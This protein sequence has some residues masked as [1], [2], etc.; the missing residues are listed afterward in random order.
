MNI[1]VGTKSPT[2]IMSEDLAK[3]GLTYQ[4]MMARLID[5]SV[6]TTID[7]HNNTKG[8]VIPYFD[9]AGRLTQFYRVKVLGDPKIKYLQIKGAPNHV[10]FPKNWNQS[11]NAV[12][13]KFCILTEG[14]KKAALACKMG[15]PAVAF[16]GVD[17]W[18][19]KTLL[20]PK[21]TEQSTGPNN[22]L[23]VKLPS[24]EFD[25]LEEGVLALG[26]QELIDYGLRSNTTWLIIYDSDSSQGTIPQVQRA[27]ARLG[28]ELRFKGFSVGQIRQMIIPSEFAG[29]DGRASL[30]DVLLSEDGHKVF[31]KLMEENF[32]QR[33][34]F[35]V[36]PNVREHI[37]KQLQKP[38]LDRKSAMNIS[39]ALLTDLDIKGTRMYSPDDLQMYYFSQTTHHLM[40]VD[41]N[42]QN[43]ASV[44][45]TEFGQL[46]YRNY[47][48]STTAD[49]RLMQWFGA[50]FSGE[51][52]VE[53]V[54]PFRIVGKPKP[55]EDIVRLQINNGSYIKISADGY[56]VMP[57]GS[58]GTLFES[59]NIQIQ[60]I[61]G[62]KLTAEIQ[63]RHGEVRETGI[64]KCWWLE[65]MNEVRL[66]HPGKQAELM[67]LLFYM[68]PF[69]MRWRGTQLPAEIVVGEA[70]S[71]K[72]TLCEI[73][74]NILCGDPKLRN[75][76]KD[77]KDWYA[78]LANCGGITVF[79]NMHMTDKSLRQSMSDEL[80]RLI[81]ELDPRISMRKYYTEADE[82]S[83]RINSV[84]GFTAIQMPFTNPD[85]LQRAIV[86]EL[87]KQ[88]DLGQI[89]EGGGF[90]TTFD[91]GWKD[92][93]LNRYGGRTAWLAHHCF[94]LHQFF[95]AVKQQWK[96][97]YQ[98]K[99][100]LV[101]L[102]QG[103]MIMAKV[104]G[105]DPSWIPSYLAQTTD[106]QISSNDWTMEGLSE[107]AAMMRQKTAARDT[108]YKYNPKVRPP[109]PL[110]FTSQKIADWAAS[111]EEHEKN[112][113]ISNTRSLGRYMQ[114]NKY[115]IAHIC[116]IVEDGKE[117]NRIRYRITEGK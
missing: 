64:P 77:Q 87:Q 30:E 48:I 83:I 88:D 33:T 50:Q 115:M 116:G 17:S 43:L 79:D 93:I 60:G 52:P 54:T 11:F 23:R 7:A 68:S 103:L 66:K 72:S 71:G 58:E 53:F 55:H 51:D 112:Y 92:R 75:T 105:M 104:F 67:A 21:G 36:H 80:C 45:E 114:A 110:Y 22:A 44:H 98:A 70:G 90:G 20:L 15:F 5:E 10:Y 96:N 95:K 81:T 111:H 28:F 109:E 12:D 94:V 69:L 29:D 59:Q 101:N 6:R 34:A 99:H 4:D 32:K 76:P 24:A 62:T 73:R 107:F 84:F 14:E 82:R 18:R 40:K 106:T 57:N 41:I 1:N 3:S 113:T 8:Y 42:K 26:L 25:N 47:S 63:K 91:S 31:R 61:D 2:D 100:R 19:N 35:P 65:V 46:L 86:L 85:L 37:A 49:S 74:L 9:I 38:K 16:G 39:M 27:A 117:N 102:E 13:R 108:E 97:D 56:K 78:S 89:K